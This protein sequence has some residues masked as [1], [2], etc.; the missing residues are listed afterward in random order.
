MSSVETDKL[1]RVRQTEPVINSYDS[2]EAPLSIAESSG[3]T[4]ASI[5]VSGSSLPD[6]DEDGS[7]TVDVSNF[8]TRRSLINGRARLDSSTGASWDRCGYVQTWWERRRWGRSDLEL[9][10]WN[11]RLG[12]LRERTRKHSQM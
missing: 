8:T 5:T 4:L 6:R 9:R 2:D 1:Q 10:E 12:A 7:V 11:G 3:Q